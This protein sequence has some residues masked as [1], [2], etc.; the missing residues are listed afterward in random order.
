MTQ[1][2]TKS[3]GKPSLLTDKVLLAFEDV[4]ADCNIIP[5]QP[6]AAILAYS[7]EDWVDEINDKVGKVVLT[8]TA[9]NDWITGRV[10]QSEA[11]KNKSDRL[12]ILIKRVRRT[13]KVSLMSKMLDDDNVKGWQ[14]N[15]WLLEKKYSEFNQAT[16]VEVKNTHSHSVKHELSADTVALIQNDLLDE[17]DGPTVIEIEAK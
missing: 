16:K 7:N 12:L 10:P 8:L 17:V 2:I 3:K 13:Q 9:F 4:I 6:N 1:A 14:R 5:G 11:M 15:T